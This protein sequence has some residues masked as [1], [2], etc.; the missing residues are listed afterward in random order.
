MF[1]KAHAAAYVISALR[2]GWYKVH[3]PVE[4]YAAYFS[5]KP[6]GFESQAVMRPKKAIEAD[7]AKLSAPG[8]ELSQKE[9]DTL[10]VLQIVNEMYA[11]GLQFLPIDVHKS[12]A[13]NFVPEDG[14]IRLPL[15]SLAGLGETAAD[16]IYKA[17]SSGEATT[18]EELK[19]V[20]GLSKTVVDTLQQNGCL[21]SMPESNQMTLF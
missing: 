5:A 6:D 4:F 3:R 14:K 19:I 15:I 13:F 9:E 16:N 12:T 17:V 20:A 10:N 1:P 18:L 8:A 2:L 7:L 11:R 21:G